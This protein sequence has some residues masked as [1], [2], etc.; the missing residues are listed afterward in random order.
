M[1]NSPKGIGAPIDIAPIVQMLPNTSA[2][3]PPM[4]RPSAPAL[5]SVIL[6]RNVNL[7]RVTYD[8]SGLGSDSDSGT[9]LPDPFSLKYLSFS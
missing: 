6:R 8:Y 3:N 2:I 9:R 1:P 7:S 5:E 4:I